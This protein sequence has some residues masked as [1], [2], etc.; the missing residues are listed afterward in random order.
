MGRSSSRPQRIQVLVD[1]NMRTSI[2]PNL[3]FF[4]SRSSYK[5]GTIV[6]FRAITRN[7]GVVDFSDGEGKGK[8]FAIVTYDRLGIFN[9]E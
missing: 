4:I 1:N 5:P 2:K 8:Y 6:D 9:V 7:A 3:R